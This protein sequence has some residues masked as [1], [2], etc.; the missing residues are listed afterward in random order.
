MSRTTKNIPTRNSPTSNSFV[1]GLSAGALITLIASA[2]LIYLFDHNGLLSISL[3][4]WPQ[5]DE[6]LRW[7]YVNLGSSIP[8][9]SILLGLFVLHMR[10]LNKHL[11]SGRSVEDI[12]RLDQLTETWMSRFFGVG[13]IWTAIGM[14]G[15]L[16]FALGDPDETIQA[17]AFA[18]LQRMV[19]GGIL[20]ALST[21]IFG[22]IGGYLMR[23]IKTITLGNDLQRFYEAHTREDSAITQQLLEQIDE[24][25]VDALTAMGAQGDDRA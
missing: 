22:G 1:Q 14:R 17:G 2:A 15:A 16:L 13:V 3:I 11:K 18:V 10:E 24:H 23:V 4:Q 8:A 9:F 25:L 12:T 21:T 20:L 7:T 6:W 19:D 5:I